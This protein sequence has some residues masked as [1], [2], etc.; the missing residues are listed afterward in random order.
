[1]TTSATA[2]TDVAAS[3]SIYNA[4]RA[5]HF[6]PLCSFLLATHL[7]LARRPITDHL[8]PMSIIDC[9]RSRKIQDDGN[10]GDDNATTIGTTVPF[11]NRNCVVRRARFA[12]TFSTVRPCV[13]DAVS[14]TLHTRLRKSI[15]DSRS[16][17]S[18]SSACAVAKNARHALR[19]PRLT[20]YYRSADAVSIEGS[21][22]FLYRRLRQTSGRA[23]TA[24]V[25]NSDDKGQISQR[26][27]RRKT[28]RTRTCSGKRRVTKRA[29]LLSV[30]LD[31]RNAVV[32]RE[33]RTGT[34]YAYEAHGV[35]LAVRLDVEGRTFR[36]EDG[37]FVASAT[38]GVMLV[39]LRAT[40]RR[41][42][43]AIPLARLDARV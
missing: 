4:S 20:Y 40:A 17:T 36:R 38:L 21:T 8:A 6:A 12:A 19:V 15:A 33:K 1:M 42:D 25:E 3:L 27:Q 41:A 43:S 11:E 23:L 30:S 32:T 37:G 18:R 13:A 24:L 16:A 22:P 39:R 14:R 29:Y 35:A 5:R 9:D 31:P 10:D 34:T 28:T 2:V 7:I 26:E